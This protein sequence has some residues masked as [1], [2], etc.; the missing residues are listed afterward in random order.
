[1]RHAVN[2]KPCSASTSVVLT[3][4]SSQLKPQPLDQPQPKQIGFVSSNCWL[5]SLALSRDQD[6]TFFDWLTNPA[7]RKLKRQALA[8]HQAVEVGVHRLCSLVHRSPLCDAWGP[9]L[10]RPMPL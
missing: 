2:G 6:Q 8:R 1:L 10:L 7:R 9:D 5:R 4:G 3:I